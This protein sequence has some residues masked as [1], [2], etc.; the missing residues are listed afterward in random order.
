[1]KRCRPFLGLL[2]AALLA[3]P[4]LFPAF[5]AE[6]APTISNL[7]IFARFVDDGRDVFNLDYETT[8]GWKHNN[9]QD[10]KTLYDGEG[11]ATDTSFKNYLRTVY[12]GREIVQN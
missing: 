5:A 2:V 7:V 8:G 10:I 12:G 9:W 11:A 6:E 3:L 1:M 4:A